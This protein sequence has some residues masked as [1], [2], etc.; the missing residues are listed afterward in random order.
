MQRDLD[1]G[2][3]VIKRAVYKALS[4]KWGRTE[5][6]YERRMSNISAVLDLYGRAWIKGLKPL[7][8]VGT[9]VIS[10]INRFLNEFDGA[11]DFIDPAFE[12]EVAKKVKVGKLGLPSGN[13]NPPV[14]KVEVSLVARSPD[15]KAWVLINANGICENCTSDAPFVS[16]TGIPYLEVHHVKR[17]A[18]KGPDTVDNAVA[19]CPNC[20]KALHYSEE[21]AAIVEFLYAQIPRLRR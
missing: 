19:L 4:D 14:K 5:N 17:L 10:V 20:H 21:R 15:V 13:Q 8:N 9:N 16:T 18:D 1:A 2:K 3:P 12:V 11:I 7:S 6:S